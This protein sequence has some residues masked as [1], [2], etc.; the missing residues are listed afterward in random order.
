MSRH[1]SPWR[2]AEPFRM[3][4]RD[5]ARTVLEIVAGVVVL[6]GI[7]FAFFLWAWIIASLPSV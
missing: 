7:A 5:N 2:Q 1:P 6:G 4:W 3:S